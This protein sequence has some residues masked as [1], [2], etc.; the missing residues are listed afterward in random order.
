MNLENYTEQQLIDYIK[1]A[2]KRFGSRLVIP[3]HHYIRSE[4][5]QLADF[6][7]DSYKLAVDVSRT[8]AEFIVFCG[9]RF[10]AESASIL[11][12]PGQHILLPDMDAGCP[13]A[14]MID[15]KTAEAAVDKISGVCSRE[16]APLVYMNSYADSKSFCGRKGGA[17]CT[18]SNAEKLVRY[19]LEKNKSIFFF[20][21][22][23]LGR[24]VAEKLGID[25]S[26]MVRVGRD[27]SLEDGKDLKNARMFLW[28]G[29][30]PV[31]QEFNT[32]DVKSARENYPDAKIIVHPESKHEVVELIDM[33]GSTQYIY[34][35]IEKS[36]DNSSWIIGTEATFVNRIAGEF[37]SMMITPLKDSPCLDMLKISLLNTAETI[38]SIDSF[39]EGSGKLINEITVDEKLKA[40]A[41]TALNRMIDI[42][43]G[44]KN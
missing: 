14:D 24:N 35:T 37:S 25:R 12:K 33:A 42:V 7:G 27:L 31:H 4:L 21:D 20:P 8:D 34:N 29:Y 40:N 19:Y 23:H 18:S 10:M 11:A 15:E 16:I 39:L 17:V 30:C 6:T 26:L 1:D 41:K 43:E 36:P 32:D 3:A 38:R 28:D 2:K 9:V 5:V 44:G 22:Y 13:M